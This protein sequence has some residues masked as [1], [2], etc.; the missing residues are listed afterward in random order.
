M[1]LTSL[2]ITISSVVLT[3]ALPVTDTTSFFRDANP[4]IGKNY[5]A[6]SYYASELN[7]TVAAF[8]TQN[9]TLSTDRARTVQKI[10]KFV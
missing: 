8:L 2:L 1:K 6:N 9:D 4:F 5:F 3:S 10:G 7:Q